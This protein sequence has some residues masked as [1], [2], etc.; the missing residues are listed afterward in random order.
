MN[1]GVYRS[2]RDLYT[3]EETVPEISDRFMVKTRKIRLHIS[4][5]ADEAKEPQEALK[6]IFE[7][8]IRGLISNETHVGLTLR[9]SC[10]S[11]IIRIPLRRIENFS[12]EM[13]LKEM[14]R[15]I[16]S[17][18]GSFGLTD[19]EVSIEQCIKSL[20]FHI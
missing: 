7:H 19:G 18:G 6:I 1:D 20:S 10:T 16:Q 14:E 3:F 17:A 12:G 5:L 15:K 13:V 9:H 11:N 2:V 8:A 4:P